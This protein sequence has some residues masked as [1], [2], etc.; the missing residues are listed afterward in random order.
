MDLTCVVRRVMPDDV[1]PLL[2]ASPVVVSLD[3]TLT[4]NAR[5]A[6]SPHRLPKLALTPVW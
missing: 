6:A 4:Q 1:P 3:K 5:G 2:G